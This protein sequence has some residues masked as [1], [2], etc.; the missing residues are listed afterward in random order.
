MFL[1]ET[2]SAILNKHFI[3]L[4]MILPEWVFIH[5]QAAVQA[6]DRLAVQVTEEVVAVEEVVVEEVVAAEVA[7]EVAEGNKNAGG[8]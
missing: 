1:S 6:A 3:V 7:A 4:I 2:V 8:I 5:I